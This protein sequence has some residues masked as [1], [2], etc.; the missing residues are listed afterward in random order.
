MRNDDLIALT[1]ARAE[2]AKEREG[3][4][5]MAAL[6]MRDDAEVLVLSPDGRTAFYRAIADARIGRAPAIGAPS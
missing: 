1:E 4:R 2:A 5:R 6:R 3:L